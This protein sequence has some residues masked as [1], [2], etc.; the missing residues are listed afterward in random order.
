MIQLKVNQKGLIVSPLKEK[1]SSFKNP[2][3]KPEN[4]TKLAE[5]TVIPVHVNIPL[6]RTVNAGLT[7]PHCC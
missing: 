2:D 4:K 3:F 1:F 6:A 7:V 5:W